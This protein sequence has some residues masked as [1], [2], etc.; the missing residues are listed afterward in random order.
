VHGVQI[1]LTSVMFTV[2]CWNWLGW[3]GVFS[4]FPFWTLFEF[5]Y[6]WRMRGLLP[7]PKCGFDPYLFLMDEDKAKSEIESHWRKKFAERG[8]PFPEKAPSGRISP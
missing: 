2:I 5:V 8:I 3:K 7:C 4:F 6:R 1:G